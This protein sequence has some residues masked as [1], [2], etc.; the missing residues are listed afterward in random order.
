MHGAFLKDG[1]ALELQMPKV[2][3]GEVFSILITE[4]DE[5]IANRF[6]NCPECQNEKGL[7]QQEFR[8]ED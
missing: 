4:V 3:L 2:I 5:M 7:W 6:L 8:L 1:R